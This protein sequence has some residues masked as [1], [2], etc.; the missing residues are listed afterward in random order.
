MASISTNDDTP[1]NSPNPQFFYRSNH[2]IQC[3]CNFRGKNVFQR[4]FLFGPEPQIQTDSCIKAKNWAKSLSFPKDPIEVYQSVLC[5]Q[6][7]LEEFFS[8]Q[9]QIELDLKRTF[10]DEAYFNGKIGENG[11]RRVLTAFCKYDPNLGYVQGMNYIVAALL[12][13]CTEVDAFWIFVGMMEKFELRDTYLP[14]FP[15]LTKHC[16]IIQLLMFEHLPALHLHFSEYNIQSKMFLTEWCFS[17][18]G[19]VIPVSEMVFILDNFFEQGWVFFYKF[20][21][22]ILKRLQT[23]LLSANELGEIVVLLKICQRSQ[24]DWKNFLILIGQGKQ[25]IG[26]GIILNE[27]KEI[28]LDEDYI[29]QLHMNFDVEKIQFIQQKK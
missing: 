13:H 23:R 28:Y 20:V 27:I 29:K 4:Y 11:L 19:S 7:E 26:W 15:G 10:P 6:L 22:F 17:L 21:I 2:Q 14:K 3:N 1:V 9:K 8:S 18:F 5:S 12:W 16:Q 24:K 25:T